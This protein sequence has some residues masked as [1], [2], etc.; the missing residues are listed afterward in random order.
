MDISIYSRLDAQNKSRVSGGFL[1]GNGGGQIICIHARTGVP[2]KRPCRIPGKWH[3]R[4]AGGEPSE[5]GQGHEHKSQRLEL[6]VAA[7]R[8]LA[9]WLSRLSRSSLSGDGYERGDRRRF[10]VAWNMVSCFSPFLGNVKL[11][12]Y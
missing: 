1:K 4:D 2:P 9:A 10:S 8:A 3:E 11:L 12:S 6:R 5:A 7:C